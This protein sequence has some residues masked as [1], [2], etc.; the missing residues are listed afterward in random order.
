PFAIQWTG[1]LPSQAVYGDPVSSLDIVATAANAAG[2]TLAADRPYD[3]LNLIP[4]LTGQQLIPQ[5]TLFWRWFRL[6]ASG[7]RG[8]VDTIYAAR[9]GSLKL[10]RSQALGVG[11]PQLYDLGSDIG[12]TQDLSPSRPGDVQSLR[13]LYRHWEAQLIAPLW[14]PPD[15]WAPTSIVLV[16]DWNR[17]NKAAAAPWA[18][19]RITAPD[20]KGTPD[21]SNWFTTTI[22]AAASDGD[23]TPGAHSFA[24]IMNRDYHKQWGGVPINVDGTTTIPSFSGTSLG[25]SNRITLEDGFYYSFRVLDEYD[26]K[27]SSLRLATMKTSASPISVS[28]SRQSPATP[29]PNDWIIIEILTSQSKSPEERIYVRWSTDTFV[30]S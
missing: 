4:Y 14:A 25:P 5:R 13:A 15:L 28:R 24:V 17:F 10:V 26:P 21:A 22:K 6:G 1:H 11:E 9:Q 19:T 27:D 12:E 30:T 8:S 16:G 23:S 7:P 2:A 20:A 18:L 3:G 29:T